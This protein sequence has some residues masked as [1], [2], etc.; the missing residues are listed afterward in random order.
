M[1][2]RGYTDTAWRKANLAKAPNDNNI[3]STY[4]WKTIFSYV[5]RLVTL[6]DANF[7]WRGHADVSWTLTPSLHRKMGI[8]P[9]EPHTGPAA[10]AEVRHLLDRARAMRYDRIDNWDRLDDFPLLAL[11]QHT[12]AATP[13]L[14]VTT[15]PMVALFFASQTHIAN[16]EETDGLLLAI[17]V[18]EK[19]AHHIDVGTPLSWGTALSTLAPTARN[20]GVYIPPVVT[21]RIMAQRSRFVFGDHATDIPYTTLP[22][23]AQADW[24]L[25]R[26]MTLFKQ[27][28]PGR[29]LIPPVVGIVIPAR[30]KETVR[31]VLT[32]TYGLSAETLF[33]DL[34]G[35]A[36]A[37]GI[38]GHVLSAPAPPPKRFG[39]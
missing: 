13:L 23:R 27:G 16:E 7:V 6:F 8:R 9:G 2:R 26:L 24:D 31:H 12:G 10:D 37:H 38:S 22:L 18:H 15:D 14:D 32:S 20:L 19:V 5:A 17:N 34:A 11:L 35:F 21:S 39:T 28:G 29:P 33:P 25:T 30:L 4:R 3:S 36:S 1:A